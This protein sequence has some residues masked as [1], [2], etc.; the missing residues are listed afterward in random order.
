MI[1][2]F[3][4][5]VHAAQSSTLPDTGLLPL[6]QSHHTQ[7]YVHAYSACKRCAKGEG[8]QPFISPGAA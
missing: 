5:F 7:T 4:V 3:C 8:Y 2:V 6:S 1:E